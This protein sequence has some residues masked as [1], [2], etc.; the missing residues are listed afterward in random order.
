[1]GVITNYGALIWGIGILIVVFIPFITYAKYFF[2]DERYRSELTFFEVIVK[3]FVIQIATLILFSIL[4]KG[5]EYA[6]PSNSPYQASFG[7][8]VFFF[9]GNL[10]NSNLPFWTIWENIANSTSFQNNA[11]PISQSVY[12]IKNVMYII[13][14]ITEFLF[15]FIFLMVF[16]FPFV[17]L[18]KHLNTNSTRFGQNETSLS[19]ILFGTFVKTIIFFLIAYIH[20][21][22]P[23]K[24]VGYIVGVPD[25]SFYNMMQK[26][27]K[28]YIIG[29]Y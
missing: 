7:L 9:G 29:R 28:Y 4:A 17:D 22:L 10:S 11:N 18:I 2:S 6:L 1:M 16:A 20:F 8:K 14:L 27:L 21:Y 3:A 5:V 13:S 25:F 12:I 23:S 26:T 24:I 19:E 15:F